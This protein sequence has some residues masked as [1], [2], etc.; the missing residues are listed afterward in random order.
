MKGVLRTTKLGLIKIHLSN[1]VNVQ[2]QNFAMEL[3][4]E[5]KPP[6]FLNSELEIVTIPSNTCKRIYL[7]T[8]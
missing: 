8:L 5:S 1:W 3:N 6:Q 2:H 7:K 4:S